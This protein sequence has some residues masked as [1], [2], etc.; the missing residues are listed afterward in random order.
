M[1]LQLETKTTMAIKTKLKM[2]MIM[3]MKMSQCLSMTTDKTITVY[4]V[5]IRV[6]SVRVILI[7]VSLKQWFT[8]L[9]QPAEY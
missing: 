1:S 3:R 8:H 7:V 2:R 5:V 6:Q 4:F 9:L